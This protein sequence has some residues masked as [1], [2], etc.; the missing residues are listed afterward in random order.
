[1][2]LAVLGARKL[3]PVKGQEAES[4][5]P[6]DFEKATADL[7]AAYG[8]RITPDDVMSNAMYPQV[9]QEWQGFKDLYGQMDKMPTHAF[10]RPMELGQEIEME[11]EPGRRT[12]VRLAG[13]S[14]VG[15]APGDKL[16]R[17]VTFEVNGE[18]WFFTVS[19]DA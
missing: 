7:T 2:R 14:N 17:V 12:Y 18:R 9:F 19:D 15:E 6:Y 11:V 16:A 3:E 1:M 4:M 10:L 13:I 8:S 5:A